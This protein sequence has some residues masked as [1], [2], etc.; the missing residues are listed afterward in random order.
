MHDNPICIRITPFTND[1]VLIKGHSDEHASNPQPTT[2]T[3]HTPYQLSTKPPPLM[4]GRCG[5]SSCM[6]LA[7]MDPRLMTN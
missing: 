4:R 3:H 2:N 5:R 6:C 7:W 1:R